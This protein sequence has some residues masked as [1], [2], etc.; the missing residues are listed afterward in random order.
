MFKVRNKK[1]VS[2][3]AKTTYKANRKRNLITIFAI[4]LTTFLITVVFA[5]GISYQ[6]TISLRSIRMNGMDYDIE[7]TEPREDQV[8]K[9]VSTDKV[10]YAGIAVKCAILERYKEINL[11][12]IQLYWLDTTCWEKQC[13]PALEF[14]KG[15]YP[16][17]ENEIM[18]SVSTLKSMGISEPQI[19]MELSVDYY[20]LSEDSNMELLQKDFVLSGYYKDYNGRKRGYV[21]KDFFDFTGAKQTDFTQG[22]LKISLKNP[23]YSEKDIVNLQ[24]ELELGANQMIRSDS[25]II[26]NFYK[27]IA[28]LFGILTMILLSGYLFI[29]NTLYISISKDIRYYGQLKTIGMTSVQLRG[30][31]YRQAF[32]NSIIGIP[33]GLLV[34][35]IV[36]KGIVPQVLHIV[37]PILSIEEIILVQ[38]WV[39]IL[40]GVFAFFTNFISSKKPAKIVGT[41]SPIEAIR[42]IPGVT[43]K[44]ERKSEDV[45]VS[46]MSIQNMARD[47]KQ[48]AV[49]FFSFIIAVTIFLIINVI[50]KQNDAVSILNTTYHYDIQFKNETVIEESIPLITEEKIEQIKKV[51][52]V[53]YIRTVSSAKAV[54]PYQEDIYGEYYKS[55][56][57]SRYSPG[58]YEEDIALYKKEP[59][60]DIFAP[61]F[62]GIDEQ[63][64]KRLNSSLG[65]ILDKTKFENGEIAVAINAYTNEKESMVGKTVKFFLPD[66]LEPD[67][68]YSIQI[69]AVGGIQESPAYFSGGYTPNLIVSEKYAEQLLGEDFI[70]LINVEYKIPFSSD[71]E[72]KVKE[73]FAQEDSISYE[74]KLDRYLEMK[75]IELQVKVFGN[76]IGIIIA[77]L[78]VLN[79]FNMM[80]ANVQNRSKEF[81]ILESIGMTT[82]QI[83]KMLA[84]E[85]ILYAVISNI[86]SLVIGIPL[87]YV[88][89][90]NMNLYQIPYSFP[91]INNL[92][93]FGVILILCSIVPV[94][95]Y[96]RTQKDCIIKRLREV[97]N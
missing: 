46:S 97:Q 65:N 51:S 2:E 15:T 31:V 95:V 33:L 78:A 47:K 26:S 55:L 21:S 35:A 9:I 66:G 70:E 18:L 23:L 50:I 52:G 11:D 87:S 44:K 56:Y 4:V 36:S 61:R 76:S 71:T 86:I 89:F 74:S 13:I 8:K 34:G 75:E 12:K 27:I 14:Y 57:D 24:K 22:T 10:K 77:F 17:K 92:L 72:E 62:I 32:W 45:E 83:R 68:E 41:C 38:P 20:N 54:I 43:K 93:L 7:L 25:D 69:A 39:Y 53:K 81:A 19:G 60:N 96:Q 37:N 30:L 58:N 73:I 88:V 94:S 67:K 5:I 91:M 82:K 80:E 64:F 29:Y 48:A 1:V 79:Y 59:E 6:N 84:L 40:A 49:I 16:Q 42:Y 85:G 90:Q 3:I 28:G 63:E